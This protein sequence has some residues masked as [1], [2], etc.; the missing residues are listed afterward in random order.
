MAVA[1]GDHPG[2]IPGHALSAA[3]YEQCVRP[4]LARRFPDLSHAAGLIGP[5]SDVLGYDTARSTD[6]DWGPRLQIVVS[7][8]ARAE[9]TGPLLAAIED[10]L[11]DTLLGVPIDLPGASD[12]PGGELTHHNSPGTARH[13][14]ITI[15]SL[16]RLTADLLG[17]TDPPTRWR[18]ARWLATP[19][20]NLLEFTAGPVHHDESGELT[21]TRAALAHYPHAVW[22]YL[23]SG[24]WQRIGQ[25]EPFVGRAGEVEDELGSRVLAAGIVRDVMR[26]ALLQRRRYAP[27]PKWLG[28]AFARSETD[29]SLTDPLAAALAA[30]AWSDRQQALV[31]ALVELGRRHDAL[32]V[33]PA[34]NAGPGP[35]FGRPFPVIW[36]EK[37]A[38]A[39]HEAIGPGEVAGLPF[40]IGGID[41]ITDSTD[42]LGSRRLRDRLVGGTEDR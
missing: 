17:T 34:L 5:G 24:R 23:M 7:E 11:P 42:A 41:E 15:T 3:L 27:Y 33:T 37:F 2:F 39:L 6:H 4:V 19:Q 36:G 20:Q 29:R 16:D 14:G 26:L 8:P 25:V 31:T 13:H 35:F 32:E 30:A 21:A 12:L 38:R 10:E 22:L 18:P 9:L 40:G 1:V 28:T